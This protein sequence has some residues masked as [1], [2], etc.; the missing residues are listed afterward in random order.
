MSVLINKKIF[1]DKNAKISFRVCLVKRNQEKLST[2]VFQAA[3]IRP[4][5]LSCLEVPS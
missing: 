1:S 4:I 2:Q 5:N 3:D